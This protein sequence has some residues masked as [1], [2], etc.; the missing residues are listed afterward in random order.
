MQVAQ[1]R[2]L[3]TVVENMWF[4]AVNKWVRD[5]VIRENGSFKSQNGILSPVELQQVAA[6]VHA[7]S[8]DRSCKHG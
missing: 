5:H 6:R 7:G 3:G 2:L 1:V 8:F 4:V